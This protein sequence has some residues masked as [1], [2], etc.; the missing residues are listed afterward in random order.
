MLCLVMGDPAWANDDKLRSLSQ[1]REN[2]DELDRLLESW[3]TNC[4]GEEVVERLQAAGLAAGIVE[5]AQ[6]LRGDPQLDHRRHF[7]GAVHSEMGMA[8][9]NMPGFRLSRS[10]VEIDRAGPCLGEHTEYVC[11]EFLGIDDS[12]FVRLLESG[13][14]E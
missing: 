5:N 1:R 12:E 11:T 4:R 7:V 8:M 10:P 3:T 2:E 13:V 6:D 14:F 9:C